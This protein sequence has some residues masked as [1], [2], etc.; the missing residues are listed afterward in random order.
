MFARI[1]K[2][3]LISF[4]I[5][6]L[7]ISA[8]M[9]RI[10]F[11][12]SESLEKITHYQPELATQIFDRKGRLI[13]NV[14]DKEL[15]FYAKFDEIPPRMIEALL[16]VEDTLFFE[17]S[18]INFDAISRAMIKNII[19]RKYLEGGSTLTQQL[20]KN[21]ALTR[22][23][24]LDRKE[25]KTVGLKGWIVMMG[26]IILM[27][28][29]GLGMFPIKPLV[30]ASNS[31]APKIYKG[32]IVIIKDTDVKKV[33]EGDIIRYRMENYYVVHR[34]VT[35]YED[36]NGDRVF[37]T[38]GDNNDDIDLYPVKESQF[39]GVIKFDIPYLGYPTLMLSR[40]LNT[41]VE[42]TVIVDK[43]RTN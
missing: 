38:K 6:A 32:D 17:H 35:I 23:K 16:A 12:L 13:A 27:V 21:I 7:I 41:G 2:I 22:D 9:I 29:F 24:T 30:I 34:V 36:N 1:K 18:G 31:M 28:C 37:I 39:A 43:G 5:F 25:V 14:F 15:R 10:F 20:V 19:A 33:K 40:L 42:D 4:V 26:V 8:Y 3:F 11:S